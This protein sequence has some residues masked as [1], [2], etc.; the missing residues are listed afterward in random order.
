MDVVKNN[1]DL[2]INNIKDMKFNLIILQVRSFSDAIYKSNLFPWSSSV[3]IKE[4]VDG[5]DVLEYFLE[6]A[7]ANDLLVYAW[8]NPYRVRTNEDVSS[9]SNLNPAYKYIGSD[10]LYVNNG[11]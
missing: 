2:M 7:H 11:I 3:S 8:I 5:F 4:G 1:I 6:R 10:T 9:I